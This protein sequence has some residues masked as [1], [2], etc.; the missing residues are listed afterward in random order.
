M[1]QEINIETDPRMTYAGDYHFVRNY[2]TWNDNTGEDT[3]PTEYYDGFVMPD[4][5]N[6]KKNLIIRCGGGELGSWSDYFS[7]KI[8]DSDN[9]FVP[10]Y[11]FPTN[12]GS[13]ICEFI[14]TDSLT[15][16][17]SAGGL[18]GGFQHSISGNKIQ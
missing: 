5:N 14:G 2:S 4:M 8:L 17:Y 7:M 12:H 18:G 3:M 10:F 6:N 1:G 16:Q 13:F 9:N 11:S 15:I